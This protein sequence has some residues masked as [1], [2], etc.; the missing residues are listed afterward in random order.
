MVWMVK[1]QNLPYF[2][3]TSIVSYLI[4]MGILGILDSKRKSISTDIRPLFNP[5]KFRS[6]YI[7]T[8]NI[9]SSKHWSMTAMECLFQEKKLKYPERKCN[10]DKAFYENRPS[11]DSPFVCMFDIFTLKFKRT[12]RIR[13]GAG[14][15]SRQIGHTPGTSCFTGSYVKFYVNQ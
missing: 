5:L 3:H 2:C 11:S 8:D 12:L 4:S 10:V 14:G 13:L 1:L 15:R 7:C 9:H 6:N